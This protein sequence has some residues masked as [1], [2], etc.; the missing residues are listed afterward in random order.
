[1]AGLSVAGHPIGDFN[2][3]YSQLG[4]HALGAALPELEEGSKE[5]LATG[6]GLMP[7]YVN[8]TGM[9]LS[10][11]SGAG[12]QLGPSCAWLS[13]CVPALIWFAHRLVGTH[14]TL[15]AAHEPLPWFAW[16]WTCAQ[17]RWA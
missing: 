5:E 3:V 4:F 17:P 8:A 15:V 13:R 14:T 2:G 10:F 9:H 7:H 12:W 11:G 16:V 1:M 6:G